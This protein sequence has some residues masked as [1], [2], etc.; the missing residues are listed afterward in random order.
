[1]FGRPLETAATAATAARIEPG[2][3]VPGCWFCSPVCATKMHCCFVPWCMQASTSLSL[4]ATAGLRLLPGSKAD[5]ILAAVRAYLAST[6]FQVKAGEQQACGHGWQCAA[7]ACLRMWMGRWADVHVAMGMDGCDCAGS[8]CPAHRPPPV[9]GAS[10]VQHQL[11]RLLCC[12]CAALWCVL[13]CHACVSSRIAAMVH[14][15]GVPVGSRSSCVYLV[16]R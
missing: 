4:K 6:P 9:A 15:P 2:L 1:M 3:V 16:T 14:N 5:E 10:W 7:G 13:T 12:C 8:R 11:G